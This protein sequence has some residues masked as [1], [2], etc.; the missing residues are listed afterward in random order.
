MR[1]TAGGAIGWFGGRRAFM[2]AMTSVGIVA[3]LLSLGGL[4][5]IL[6]GLWFVLRAELKK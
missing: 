2:L 3:G 6:C 5:M 4:L 1:E